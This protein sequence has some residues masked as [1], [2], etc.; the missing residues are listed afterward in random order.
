MHNDNES[1]IKS[2]SEDRDA[3]SPDVGKA[4]HCDICNT[5]LPNPNEG[6]SYTGPAGCY[7]ERCY[8]EATCDHPEGTREFHYDDDGCGYYIW[9]CDHCGHTEIDD[10]P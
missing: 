8:R 2:H 4:M 7:C 1:T 9:H 3:I 10:M 6:P 5:E